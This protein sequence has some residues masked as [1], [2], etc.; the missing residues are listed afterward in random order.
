M[1]AARK[2]PRAARLRTV[3][4]DV[5]RLEGRAKL[6]GTAR[7]VADLDVPGALWGLTVR[8]PHPH[9][10]LLAI[11]RDPAFDWT[12]VTV[13]TGADLARL[14][15]ENVVALIEDDQPFL[16]ER[17]S[18]HAEE[19]VA[20]V[21][22][23]T[24][25]AAEAAARHLVIEWRPLAAELDFERS[26]AVF[27]EIAITR[28]D[29]GGELARAER[30]VEGDY[31]F[32]AQEQAYLENN[33]VV[34]L[35][36]D[37]GGVTLLGSMQCPYYVHRGLVRL[38]RAGAGDVRVVQTVTGGGFGGKEEYPIVIAGHAALLARASGRPVRLLYDRAEDMVATTKRHPG[39]IRHRTGFDRDGRL[40]AVEVEILLDGGAYATLSPVVLSRAALHAV[41][42]YAC[43]HVSVRARAVATHTPPNG[44]FR[45]FGVPQAC[46][47]VERHLDVA[48]HALGVDRVELR[49]RNLLDD[50]GTLPTGQRVGDAGASR[51]T[52]DAVLSR[53]RFRSRERAHAAFNRRARDKRRGLG[54]ACYFHGTGFT[55]SGEL[56]LAS[57]V[58]VELAGGG[59]VRIL[60]AS[61]EI[62]Q[63][64]RTVFAQ[65]VAETLGLP[66]DR[67]E[68][69]DA[70]TAVVPDSGPTVASRTVA[71][72]GRI[73]VDAARALDAALRASSGRAAGRPWSA[74]DFAAAA[75]RHLAAGGAARF[76]A[77]FSNPAGQVWDDATYRGDA[78]GAYAWAAT[79]VEVEV[80]LATF[81][82]SVLG[83]TSAQE[84]GRAVHPRMAE[85]QL[86]GGLAQALGWGL[87]EDVAFR[88]GRMANGRLTNYILPT[89]ADLP[90]VDLVLL[91][92]PWAHGPFGAKGIGE[93]PMDGGAP[94]AVNAVCAALGVDLRRIPATP[95]RIA[96][97]PPAPGA[98]GGA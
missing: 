75:A 13:V 52:L 23:P 54:L 22:A 72:V 53:S 28:G 74:R 14:G 21:A 10:E 82:V 12:G 84:I 51:Q 97:A 47:A 87:F 25:E 8:S 81:E 18:R 39:R 60:T 64:T 58:A 73:L 46:W 2:P 63:G 50:G 24:R 32:G 49:R 5:L 57:R 91:E 16:V 79:V 38:L 6:A 55:G 92:R 15:C 69:A 98:E 80:D 93:L 48:A 76:E 68:V 88:D 45:G 31:R 42:P 4:R 30:V 19:P 71:I 20:L 61:T 94:A 37:G 35:P 27:K 44:A 78:Y 96:E 34:A 77:R 36:G 11:R 26:T 59:R 66:I 56:K 7:Y 41:G 89:S 86:E 83:V 1:P 90:A 3:G 70:D 29:A 67:V 65:L 9:A 40:R 62:G 33:G 85:G 17:I 43:E 95:E